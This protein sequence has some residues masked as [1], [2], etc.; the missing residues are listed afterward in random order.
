[1]TEKPV[2]REQVWKYL[3]GK[4][5]WMPTALVVLG[6]AIRTAWPYVQDDIASYLRAAVGTDEVIARVASL[7]DRV[8]DVERQ[9]NTLQSTVNT[10]TGQDGIIEWDPL[11]SRV[12]EPVRVDDESFVVVWHIRRTVIG[13]E[14]VYLRGSANVTGGD[15]VSRTAEILSPTQQINRQW[16]FVESEIAMPARL[17][18]GLGTLTFDLTYDC[19]GQIVPDQ[20]GPMLI[21]IQTS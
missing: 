9:V 6:W 5:F 10:L 12:L 3:K 17:R 1:M 8:G 13:D 15:N 21:L 16:R 4:Y 18:P 7:E 2:T 14:C 20:I 11:L 19:G